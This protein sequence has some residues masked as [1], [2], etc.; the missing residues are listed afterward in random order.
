VI[1]EIRKKKENEINESELAWG[2]S[3]T[4]ASGEFKE[5]NAR[6]QAIR[7]VCKRKKWKLEKSYND[8]GVKIEI[9]DAKDKA[10]PK[11]FAN[12]KKHLQDAMDKLRFT[13]ALESNKREVRKLIEQIMKKT[14]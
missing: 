1:D 10:R 9:Y 4:K 12:R 6:L 8:E 7:L 2:N 5:L 14:F 3:W 13:I 11:S